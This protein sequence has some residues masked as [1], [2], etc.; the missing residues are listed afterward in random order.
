MIKTRT[1]TNVFFVA[2]VTFSGIS[3]LAA[4]VTPVTSVTAVTYQGRLEDGSG[5][6]N[7]LHDFNFTIFNAN[8][9]F[10]ISGPMT[11]E[12][13][14]VTNGLFTVQLEFDPGIWVGPG[15]NARL[16]DVAV[17][18]T[19]TGSFTALSPRQPI[20]AVPF[21]LKTLGVSGSS[22]S[23]PDSSPSNALSVDNDGNVGVGTI[24]PQ[25]PLQVE[26][27]NAHVRLRDTGRGNY[28][29]IYT[30]NHPNQAISGNLLFV[31]GPTGVFGFIEKTTGVY[32]SGSD[33]RLKEEIRNLGSVLERVLQLR[34]VTYRFKSAPESAP[35]TVGLIAQDVEPLFPEVVA[36]HAN[37]KSLAYAELVPI[38][39]GA[40]Q[41]LNQKLE[42]KL[43]QKDAEIAELKE[44]VA[45]LKKLIIK[46]RPSVTLAN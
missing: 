13:V 7:G 29:N 37:M 19:G 23:A 43:Q 35:R 32:F 4:Q 36:E 30:E 24:A 21:A 18:R 22:L 40:I 45:E 27:N 31:P 44:T 41:E 33:A 28:W 15:S 1:A 17:R 46:V 10:P 6:A 42:Q 3:D 5:P 25:A 26:G 9:I 2:I 16:L 11:K 12:A 34:P 20:T 8:G 38:T 39:V 14:P